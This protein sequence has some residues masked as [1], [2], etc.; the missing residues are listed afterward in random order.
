[1]TVQGI[2]CQSISQRDVGPLAVMVSMSTVQAVFRSSV[3]V[4]VGGGRVL[5]LATNAEALVDRPG[6][7]GRLQGPHVRAALA[8]IGW[9]WANVLQLPA[10]LPASSVD[11]LAL[12]HVGNG[13]LAARLPA[14]SLSGGLVHDASV[15]GSMQPV[16]TLLSLAR[17]EN[18]WVA[19]VRERLADVL[20]GRKLLGRGADGIR[21]YRKS[22]DKQIVSRPRFVF[23]S[24]SEQGIRRLRHP[25]DRRRR[26]FLKVLASVEAAKRPSDDQIRRVVA[27]GRPFD[28]LLSE[29]IHREAA[30]LWARQS[31]DSRREELRHR[32]HAVYFGTQAVSGVDDVHQAIEVLLTVRPSEGEAAMDWDHC[33]AL[34]EVL[35]QRWSSRSSHRLGTDEAR[36]SIELVGRVMDRMDSLIERDSSLGRHW[37]ER[38]EVVDR[39]LIDPLRLSRSRRA[40]R[41]LAN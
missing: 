17:I 23:R 5:I 6:L 18:E 4:A 14:A 9:D 21:A 12:N 32:L 38:R 11:S 33:N 41:V 34:L 22:V 24:D 13:W 37:A 39:G 19:E 26:Q 2:F 31:G 35:K 30:A 8:E 10:R 29:F 36:L 28:P 25:V 27:F 40:R 15:K 20:K 7:I 16:R 1:L 3:L